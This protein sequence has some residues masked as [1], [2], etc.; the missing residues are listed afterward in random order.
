MARQIQKQRP[1]EAVGYMLEGDAH[2]LKKS[3]NEAATAYRNGLKQNAE[4]A[5]AIKL[6]AVVVAGGGSGEADRFA[7]SWM[8]EHTK[9]LQFRLY[10]AEAATARKDYATASKYYRVLVDAQPN[11]PAM[12]NNL[13]WALAQNKDCLLYTS[14]CV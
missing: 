11:N 6:H 10:L 12:L 13:A 1:K 7:D 14:R 4:T 8:K 5:L 2:A 3:W 9:D